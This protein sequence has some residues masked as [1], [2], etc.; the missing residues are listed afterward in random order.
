MDLY[1][2]SVPQCRVQ[3]LAIVEHLDVF[4]NVGADVSAGGVDGAVD[5][6]V[7]QRPV[8]RFG[9]R[10]VPAHAGLTDTRGQAVGGRVSAELI[11]RI[12]G[13]FK[14]SMQH[15]L[16]EPIV[17]AGQGFRLVSSIRVSCGACR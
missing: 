4:G 13:R 16:V 10:I 6:L 8:E 5:E 12:L 17:V 3:P 7:F 2:G 11:T 15:R 14:G 1:R 9:H